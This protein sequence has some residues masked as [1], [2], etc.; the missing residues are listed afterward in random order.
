LEEEQVGEVDFFVATSGS[1]EDNVMTCL[2]A[3]NL[4]AKNCLTLIHRADYAK[5]ISTSGRHFGVVA[6]VSP[7]E[8][9]RKEISRYVT[10]EKFHVVRRL[11]DGVV[12]QTHISKGAK[13]DGKKVS[14]IQWP[15]G[16]VL[17]GL[18]KGLQAIVP[19]ADAELEEGDQ[20]FAMVANKA[21]KK[22]LKLLH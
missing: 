15:E 21:E 22:F 14:E 8:A 17:V 12:L 16:C 7:R 18:L 6:A 11:G 9:S 19:G 13:A 10:T 20:V 3:H 5:A 4:G 2:Q 1:D